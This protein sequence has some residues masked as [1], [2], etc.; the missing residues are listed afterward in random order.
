MSNRAKIHHYQNLQS[1][2]CDPFQQVY[3]IL[4]PYTHIQ[5]LHPN[6]PKFSM[7]A[8]PSIYLPSLPHYSSIK[9]A[10]CGN[11]PLPVVVDVV[12]P[13]KKPLDPSHI[14]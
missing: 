3:G 8:V 11:R 9:C 7:L 14:H 4:R 2:K 6:I 10:N 5:V 12:D 1:F 13:H